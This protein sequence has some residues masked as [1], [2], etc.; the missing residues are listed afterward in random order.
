MSSHNLSHSRPTKY[1]LCSCFPHI[2]ILDNI[3]PLLLLHNAKYTY[4]IDILC[5]YY[6]LPQ[7]LNNK[8]LISLL[9]LFNPR[10]FAF[11]P[12]T[13]LFHYSP[14][15]KSLTKVNNTSLLSCEFN[16]IFC[17]PYIYTRDDYPE[18]LKIL[19]RKYTNYW[20]S[21]CNLPIDFNNFL[22]NGISFLDKPV[23][24]IRTYDEYIYATRHGLRKV[25]IG[26]IVQ[27]QWWKDI[28]FNSCINIYSLPD[29][30]YVLCVSRPPRDPDITLDDY[31]S[32]IYSLLLSCE[33]RNMRLI[34]S[35]HVWEDTKMV[36]DRLVPR[37]ANNLLQ[38]ITVSNIPL[39]I[40]LYGAKA[41]FFFSS[42]TGSNFF[43]QSV[44]VFQLINPLKV[45]DKRVLFPW[46]ELIVDKPQLI[47]DM[48]D[49]FLNSPT[50]PLDS[51]SHKYYNTFIPFQAIPASYPDSLF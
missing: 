48:F 30:Q 18:L 26:D 19:V 22:Y 38:F 31:C 50:V 29:S 49:L 17:D 13:N 2:G 40:L 14:E 4:K 23:V 15:S 20:I 45:T 3:F 16:G 44:P 21:H 35:P 25:L 1:F 42:S 11:H 8:L 33:K 34:L 28:L 12:D 9:N 27:S 37:I 24:C 39:S 41:G 7:L 32:Y 43:A 36:Y 47:E 6:Q 46:R 10:I 51:I 5:Q